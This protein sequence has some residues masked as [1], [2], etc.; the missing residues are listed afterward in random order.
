MRSETLQASKCYGHR[1]SSAIEFELE[2]SEQKKPFS[3][4]RAEPCRLFKLQKTNSLFESQQ[5]D[6]LEDDDV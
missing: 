4:R 3:I 1:H 2:G 6:D 5:T